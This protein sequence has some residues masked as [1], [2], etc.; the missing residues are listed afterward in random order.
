MNIDISFGF[1][2]RPWQQEVIG[3]AHLQRFAVWALHRRAG[4][5][6]IALQ[7]LLHFAYLTKK[8]LPLYLYVAPFLRQA[9]LIAW[10]RLKQMCNHM[11]GV[12]MIDINESD[13]SIRFLDNGTIVQK[14]DR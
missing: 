12:G 1:E 5:T 6:E 14:S 9:K 11:I 10:A 13:L 7:R 8:D 3:K 4:K 2:A